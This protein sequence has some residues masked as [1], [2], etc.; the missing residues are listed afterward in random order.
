MSL[1]RFLICCSGLKRSW[2]V[3]AV[4]LFLA[5]FIP[6]QKI[7]TDYD[8]ATDFSKLKT[9]SWVQG[10]PTPNPNLDFYIKDVVNGM[11]QKRGMRKVESST[12]ADVLLTY[13]AAGDSD[14]HVGGFQD[15]T[16]IMTG[17][18]PTIGQTVR[19]PAPG[20]SPTSTLLRKGSVVFQMFNREA[21]QLVW[22]G[23]AQGTLDERQGER[24]LQI[25]KALNKIFDRF[26]PKK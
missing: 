24:M 21:H 25:N 13:H 8:K 2:Q 14:L 16:S 23:R 20:M 1:P 19:S 22:S 7:S 4:L 3:A 15:P 11:L 12:D 5:T 9:Y 10:T 17:G 26:P 6:A 18:V